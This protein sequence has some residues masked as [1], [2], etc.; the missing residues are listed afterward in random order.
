MQLQFAGASIERCNVAVVLVKSRLARLHCEED[1]ST[2]PLCSE[3]LFAAGTLLLLLNAD[4]C[5]DVTSIEA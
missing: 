2:K 5:P 3:Q 1:L 4:C